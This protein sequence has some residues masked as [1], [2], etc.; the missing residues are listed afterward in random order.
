MVEVVYDELDLGFG[1]KYPEIV[2][3]V[4]TLREARELAREDAQDKG[5]I[6][7]RYRWMK[8]GVLFAPGEK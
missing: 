4:E 7:H 8:K 5:R 3:V 6:L 1:D 2:G